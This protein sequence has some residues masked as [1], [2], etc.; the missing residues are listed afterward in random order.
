MRETPN[1][2]PTVKASVHV[3]RDTI[4]S[5]RIIVAGVS[6]LVVVLACAGVAA[7]LE[8]QFGRLF[9]R[10]GP[11]IDAVALPHVAGPPPQ[12]APQRDLADYRRDKSAWLNEYGWVDRAGRVVHVP[13]DRAMSLIAQRNGRTE[14]RP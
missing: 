12:P 11:A 5:W 3:E 8:H 4:A 1:A 6:V 7:T 9:D 2:A 14:K 10:A 13:I